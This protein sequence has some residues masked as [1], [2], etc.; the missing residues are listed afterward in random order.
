MTGGRGYPGGGI[1]N[2]GASVLLA[3]HFF[4]ALHFFEA[5]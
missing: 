2:A 5:T 3:L 1:S 4:A